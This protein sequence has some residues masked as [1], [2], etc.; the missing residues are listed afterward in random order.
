MEITAGDYSYAKRACSS[1]LETGGIMGMRQNEGS[2]EKERSN[3][4]GK[5]KSTKESI[6]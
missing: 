1:L 3:R 2:N 5:G 6:N 4:D